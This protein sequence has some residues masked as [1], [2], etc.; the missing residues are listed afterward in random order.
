MLLWTVLAALAPCCLVAVL[1]RA[2]NFSGVPGPDGADPTAAPEVPE[3]VDLC[4]DLV[5]RHVEKQRLAGE[6]LAGRLT[7][8]EAAAR[9]RDLDDQP[10]TAGGEALRSTY[11]GASDEECQCR[12]VL[13]YVR[14]VLPDWPGAHPAAVKRLEAELRDLLEHGNLRLPGPDDVPPGVGNA[15]PVAGLAPPRGGSDRP[16]ARK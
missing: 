14:V 15:R 7:L 6:V 3:V 5:R 9:F 4:Q 1:S 11:P 8:L 2:T 13:Q 12:A 10:R 16:G